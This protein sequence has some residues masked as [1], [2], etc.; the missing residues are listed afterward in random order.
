M[1]FT[2]DMNAIIDIDEG[3]EPHC[4]ALKDLIS[5]AGKNDIGVFYCVASAAERQ[6]NG[7]ISEKYG[8]YE[9]RIRRLGLN[10]LE[11]ITLPQ[12]TWGEFYWDKAN[13][14]SE[15]IGVFQDSVARILFDSVVWQDLEPNQRRDVE[16]F[17]SHV[18]N[19]GGVLVTRDAHFLKK[20]DKLKR[21]AR[22]YNGTD[23][24]ILK[25]EDALR[26]AK[27]FICARVSDAAC[28]T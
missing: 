2:L 6:K 25:P 22:E 7:N 5:L 14:G 9:D 13:W 17:V 21:I 4:T 10:H 26:K 11:E 20:L 23:I 12:G 24:D 1:R 8:D 18:E 27:D 16:T 15:K 3:R 28:P 19:G